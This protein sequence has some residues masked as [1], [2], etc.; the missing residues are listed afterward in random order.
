MKTKRIIFAA[1]LIA[2][3]FFVRIAAADGPPQGTA[4]LQGDAA[5]PPSAQWLRS[6]LYFGIGPL[7]LADKDM[8][9]MHWRAFLDKE[10]T[11]RFP[12][13]LTVLDGYGQWLDQGK[14]EPSRLRSKVLVILHED[15]PA[16]RAA[17]DAIRLAWKTVTHD[18]SVLLATEKVDVSF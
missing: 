3:A 5:R 13:G 18:Q 16:N 11:P 14:K 8:G 10:V 1:A 15:S 12:D 17:I 7:D 9:E 2:C 6:E 4:A